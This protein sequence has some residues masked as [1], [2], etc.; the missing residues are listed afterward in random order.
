MQDDPEEQLAPALGKVLEHAYHR[1]D[2][3]ASPTYF[4]WGHETLP[5]TD[6]ALNS[7]DC[8]H[9]AIYVIRADG[10]VECAA[11][12]WNEIQARTLAFVARRDKDSGEVVASMKD[13]RWYRVSIAADRSALIDDLYLKLAHDLYVTIP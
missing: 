13:G 6:A 4:G 5:A 1:F 8:V 9:G 10:S 3:R 12:F 2:D 11:K 7:G